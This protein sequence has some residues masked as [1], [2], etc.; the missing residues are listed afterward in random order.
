MP[1]GLQTWDE[2]GN[3]ILDVSQ[4]LGRILAIVDIPASSSGTITVPNPDLVYGTRWS[5]LQP[6]STAFV[7]TAAAGAPTGPTLSL[8]GT[9]LTYSNSYAYAFKLILGVY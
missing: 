8:S 7:A 4:Y 3:L 9:T 6:V 5:L 1:Q 2:S